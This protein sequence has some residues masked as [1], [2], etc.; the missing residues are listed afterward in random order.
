MDSAS[1]RAS[2]T[3]STNESKPSATGTHTSPFSSLNDYRRR[4]QHTS[5]DSPP[6][7]SGSHTQETPN[8]ANNEPTAPHLGQNF[9]KPFE[10]KYLGKDEKEHF[11]WTTSW[12]V[13]WRVIGALILS[14]GDDKGLMLPPRIAPVQVVLVP[15]FYKEA[16]SENILKAVRDLS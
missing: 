1:G 12:G 6:T 9:S 4:K 7:S 5:Q 14:H 11:A 13:S 8:P 2:K 16:D 15:I 3:T 10:I